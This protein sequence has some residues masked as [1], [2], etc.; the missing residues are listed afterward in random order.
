MVNN[1]K[2]IT[3][4]RTNVPKE[5]MKFPDFDYPDEGTSYLPSEKILQYLINYADNFNLQP[6][7]KVNIFIKIQNLFLKDKLLVL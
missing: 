7:I 6:I 5:A 4:F 2:E 1:F 3:F